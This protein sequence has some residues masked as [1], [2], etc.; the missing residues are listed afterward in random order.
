MILIEVYEAVRTAGAVGSQREFS[1]AWLGRSPS[2]LSSMATRETSRTVSTGVLVTLVTRL[3]TH[4]VAS[5]DCPPGLA[6]L[7]DR[8]M[9]EIGERITAGTA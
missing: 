7:A 1:V 9:A 5:P 4:I 2:Y 3:R 8:L 6:P